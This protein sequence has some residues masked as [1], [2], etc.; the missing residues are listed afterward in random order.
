[1]TQDVSTSDII[2]SSVAIVIFLI[3]AYGIG[4]AH[5]A[6]KNRSFTRAWAP[7]VPIVSGTVTYDQSAAVSSSLHG[8]YKGHA[9]R[10]IMSPQRNRYHFA[11]PDRYN[12][13]EVLLTD[14]AGVHDWKIYHEK[15]ILGIG[16]DGWQIKSNDALLQARL[17]ATSIASTLALLGTPLLQYTADTHTLRFSNDITP[18]LVLIPRQFSEVLELLVHLARVQA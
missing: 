3:V 2:V 17:E 11:S 15:S 13:F 6:W 14:V 8:T 9:V 10:A 1:M 7:L 16:R 18:N 5:S 4:R 12:E